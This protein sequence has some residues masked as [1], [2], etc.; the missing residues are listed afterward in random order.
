MLPPPLSPPPVPT[1]RASTSRD[2]TCCALL[3]CITAKSVLT[4]VLAQH[5]A[6]CCQVF[7]HPYNKNLPRRVRGGGGRGREVYSYSSDTVEGPRA[8]AV[9]LTARQSSLTR[10]RAAP[11]FSV[12]GLVRQPSYP[13]RSSVDTVAEGRSGRLRRSGVV[14]TEAGVVAQ[15]PVGPALPHLGGS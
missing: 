6:L 11:L 12:V 2:P 5:A 1:T 10:V 3:P 15:V 13:L 9:K 8:H 4:L 7:V 14:L